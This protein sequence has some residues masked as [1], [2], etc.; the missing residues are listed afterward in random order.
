MVKYYCHFPRHAYSGELA[1]LTTSIVGR[2]ITTRALCIVAL[3][4]LVSLAAAAESAVEIEFEYAPSFKDQTLVYLA[5]LPDG[6]IH[7]EVLSRPE[8]GSE[9]SVPKWKKIKEIR[10]AP[11]IFSRLEREFETSDLKSAGVRDW[12]AMLDGS[13]WRLKKKH[14][15]L[16]IEIVAHNPDLKDEGAPIVK[17]AQA[18]AEAASVDLFPK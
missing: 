3:T 6:K 11:D 9:S 13:R 10:V 5:R 15:S 1:Q 8:I 4:L 18:I 14:G 17:L 16:A 12:P 7:C 2:K